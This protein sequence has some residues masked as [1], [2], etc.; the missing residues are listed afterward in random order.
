MEI[1][2]VRVYRRSGQDHRQIAG[3]VET[4]GSGE[5]RNFADLR[6]LEE[7]LGA[8]DKTEE[9]PRQGPPA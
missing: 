2:I 4:V 6:E 7:A 5:T 3:Q 8:E 9:R 1:Y